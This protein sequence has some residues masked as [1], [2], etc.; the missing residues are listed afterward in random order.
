MPPALIARI[1]SEAVRYLKTEE[2][3]N[4]Y[5][6][7]GADPAPSTPDQFNKVMQDEHARV[8]KII[9]DIGLKPQF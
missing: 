8:K 1:N 4:R 9:H 6:Q 2:I 5:Q 7:N 3:R